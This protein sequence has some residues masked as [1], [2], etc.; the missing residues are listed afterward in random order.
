MFVGLR[1]P[2]ISLDEL[3]G[4]DVRFAVADLGN[5]LRLDGQL[6]LFESLVVH[7]RVDLEER[8]PERHFV[9]LVGLPL[10]R[11]L[12][13]QGLHWFLGLVWL[14][15]EKAPPPYLISGFSGLLL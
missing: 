1:L 8:L 15:L 9:R 14:S 7:L 3:R 11:V 6:L 2:P 10:V 13:I 4:L 5:L 12:G